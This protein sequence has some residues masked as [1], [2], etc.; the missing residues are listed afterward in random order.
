MKKILLLNLLLAMLL[1][2][3]SVWAADGDIFTAPVT[4]IQ[5]GETSQEE[6]RFQVLSES[7]KTCETYGTY[8]EISD[9]VTPAFNYRTEGDVIIPNTVNGYIVT[10]IGDYSFCR[11]SMGHIMLPESINYVGKLAFNECFSLLEIDLELRLLD[12]VRIC[13]MPPYTVKKF[14]LIVLLIAIIYRQ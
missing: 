7:A 9:V 2:A 12:D 14:H 1:G 11:C 13:G 4:V 10:G 5:N 3:T 8:D 6:M